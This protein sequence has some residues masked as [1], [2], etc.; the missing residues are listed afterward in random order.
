MAHRGI[1]EGLAHA[2]P[3]TDSAARITAALIDGLTAHVLIGACTPGEA[4][5]ALAT[6]LR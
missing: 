6:H 4:T 1:R 5:S 3:R 2:E